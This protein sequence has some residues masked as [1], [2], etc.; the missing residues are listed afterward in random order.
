GNWDFIVSGNAIADRFVYAG[1]QI[2]ME[3]GAMIN[4][5]GTND[6][7]APVAEN[8]LSLQLRGAELADS[9]LQRSG[10]LRG[11]ALSVDTRVTGVFNGVAWVGTPLG[12]VSGF[13]ALIQH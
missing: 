11:V 9:P 8:I 5:A 4:V 7:S 6:V 13:V 12:N 1:G 3:P 2:Y 10:D